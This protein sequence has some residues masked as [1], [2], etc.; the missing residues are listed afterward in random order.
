MNKICSKNFF[1][2]TMGRGEITEELQRELGRLFL[3]ALKISSPLQQLQLIRE[4]MGDRGY[5]NFDK[6]DI[7]NEIAQMQHIIG[8]MAQ[9]MLNIYELLKSGEE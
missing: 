7:M 4:K 6:G 5:R 1:S 2:K 8:D 3:Q 9:E